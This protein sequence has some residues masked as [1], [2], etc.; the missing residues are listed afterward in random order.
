M[1]EQTESATAVESVTVQPI[2][3][4]L[5]SQPVEKVEPSADTTKGDPAK[6]TNTDATPAPEKPKEKSEVDKA[7]AAMSKQIKEL[8]RQVVAANQPRQ[9]VQPLDPVSMEPADFENEINSRISQAVLTS[10]IQTSTQAAAEKHDDFW[11]MVEVFDEHHPPGSP[12]HMDML[13]AN[14]PAEFAYKAA[15]EAKARQEIGD[16]V[17]YA[18]KIRQEAELKAL[19]TI[20]KLVEAKLKERLTGVLPPSLASEQTQGSRSNNPTGYN[21]P[22]PLSA[23]LKR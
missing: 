4:I 8:K 21:G 7:F 6:D 11:D 19:S 10:K 1:I 9:E 14:N 12:V 13:K 15:K 2:E 23:I 5:S 17:Q 3:S 16:P 20:D 18:E 22:T